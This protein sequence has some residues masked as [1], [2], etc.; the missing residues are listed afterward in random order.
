MHSSS[1]GGRKGLGVGSV[2]GREEFKSQGGQRRD[3][4][5]REGGYGEGSGGEGG[6]S[7]H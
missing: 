2:I 1:K 4:Q 5:R 3:G 6:T 7:H